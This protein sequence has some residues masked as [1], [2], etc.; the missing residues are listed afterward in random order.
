MLVDAVNHRERDGATEIDAHGFEPLITR[1]FISGDAHLDCDVVFAVKQEL[2]SQIER[3][4]DPVMPDSKLATGPRDLPLP[5]EAGR[6]R[7]ARPM[8]VKTTED[9]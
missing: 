2:V 4:T 6:R 8:M 5:D 7:R 3:R 1:V 9:A